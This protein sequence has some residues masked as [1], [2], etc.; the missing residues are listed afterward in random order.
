MSVLL[1]TE[2]MLQVASAV[3]TLH[4]ANDLFTHKTSYCF[5]SHH[6]LFRTLYNNVHDWKMQFSYLCISTGLEGRR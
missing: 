1:L 2:F 5:L 3:G 4:I 6:P